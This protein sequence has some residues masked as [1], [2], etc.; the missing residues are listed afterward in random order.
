MLMMSQVGLVM[1]KNSVPQQIPLERGVILHRTL[2]SDPRQEYFL[3]LPRKGGNGAKIF[4]TVHGTS[5]NAEEH[6][7]GFAPFAERYGVVVI[8]PYFPAQ[9]FPDYQRLGRKDKG[10]RADLALQAMVQEVATITGASEKKLYLFGYSGGAQFAHRYMLA[11]PE[12][13]ARVVLGAPGWYTFPDE[14]LKYPK[15]I[16][17]SRSLPTVQ[18][19]PTHFLTIPVCVLVGERD[20][21]RDGE[22][23][24]SEH[25]D[26]LQGTTR[27]ERGR[28]WVDA[29]TEQARARGL[30]TTYVFHT[31]P[32]SPHSFT[33]S[34]RRG[35][36]GELT[37]DFLFGPGSACSDK[38]ESAQ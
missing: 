13:V 38:L 4:V 34:M 2:V 17:T 15:G 18:F 5:R 14:N 16:Q 12:R 19:N 11:Y 3:Y 37:F 24:K 22:L 31:L 10:E 33:R 21:R 7:R 30:A 25:I 1:A 26:L 8:A 36:M 29:M 6:A 23:N 28:R 27:L 9:R 20:Q 32:R 35:G